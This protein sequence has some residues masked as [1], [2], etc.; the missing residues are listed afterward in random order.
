MDWSIE[1][2]AEMFDTIAKHYYNKNFGTL[3]KS[4]LDLLMFHFYLTEEVEEDKEKHQGFD[5][6]KVSDYV[7]SKQLGITQQRVRAL[8]IRKQ[9]KYPIEFDW[10]ESLNLL[11]STA[12]FDVVSQ[13]IVI[14]I[15]DPNLMIEI[16]NKIEESGGYIVGQTGGKTLKIRIEYFM[17]LVYLEETEKNKKEILSQ[18]KKEIKSKNK[19]ESCF[20]ENHIG[21]SMIDLGVSITNIIASIT[22]ILEPNNVLLKKLALLLGGNK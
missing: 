13:K 14:P 4:D 5:F 8:K 6:N 16:Q 7:I 18:I 1:K 2:K 3:S 11:I 22:T 12:R 21:K 10:K 15:P 17:E 9:L 20:D 19:D